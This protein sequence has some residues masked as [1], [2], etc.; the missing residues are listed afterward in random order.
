MV[1]SKKTIFLSSIFS[2][3]LYPYFSFFNFFRRKHSF[4][5]LEIKKILVTEY[6]RIGDVLIIIKA[7]NSIKKRFPESHLI[8]ICNSS[9]EKLA[10]HLDLA[11]E[12]VPISVPWTNW[13][14]SFFDWYKT[15]SIAKSFSKKN[16]DLA[17]DFKGDFRNSWFLWNTYPKISFGYDTTG[18]GYFFTNPRTMNQDLHQSKRAEALVS[19]VGCIPPKE[20]FDK[21]NINEEGAVVVHIGATDKK[22]S[23]PMKY[24]IELIELLSDKLKITIVETVESQLLIE[25]LKILKIEVEYFKGDLIELKT[26]LVNQRCLVAP[27]SMAGHLAAYVQIPV[28]SLFGSQNPNLTRPLNKLGTI[29]KPDKPCNHSSNHWRLCRECMESIPPLKVYEAICNEVN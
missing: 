27:D 11:D 1:Y 2:I 5:N 23:W 26:W 21:I 6:H 8:L 29:I 13:S 17:F 14:W 10:K 4:D 15:R 19:I 3:L 24:W 7:L 12:V 28:I 16:I 9:V 25:R 22:R 20:Q 18:G